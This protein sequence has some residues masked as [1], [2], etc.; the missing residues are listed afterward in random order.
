MSIALFDA[1]RNYSIAK[2]LWDAL[3]AYL[4]EDAT[5]SKKFW[6]QNSPVIKW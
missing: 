5:T 3:E 2:D 1:Y 4:L 6:Q